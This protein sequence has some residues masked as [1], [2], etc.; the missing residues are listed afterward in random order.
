MLIEIHMIQNHS[1]SNL[2][3]DDLGAPKTCLFGGVPRARVSSQ[4]L[5]RSIRN[6]GN[7]DDVHNRGAG[8]FFEAMSDFIAVRTKFFPDLV[9]KA[10]ASSN[11]PEAERQKIV[12]SCAKIAKKEEGKAQRPSEE[13]EMA[14]DD[15]PRLPQLV[16]LE[17]SEA[18]EFVGKLA[19]MRQAK[20]WKD[21]YSKWIEGKLEKKA[22]ANFLYELSCAYK[23]RSVDIALFGRMTTSHAFEDVEAAMQAAHAISTHAVVNEV[24]YFTAV[25]DLGKTGGGAGHVDEA[26]FNS[27]CFYKYF[28]LDWDQLVSNLTPRDPDATAKQNAERLAAATLGHFIRAAA[29]T[30]PTGK[31][32]SF[33][34]NCEPSGILVEIKKNGKVP[35]S[36]ANAFAEPA[37]KIGDPPD[38]A[39]DCVSL[40]GRSIAQLGDHI[41]QLRKAY[42]TDS[43][44]LW[45]ALPLWRFPLQG[46]EREDDGRKA[47]VRNEKGEPTDKDKPPVRFASKSFDLLGGEAD[48]PPGLVEAMIEALG[49]NLKWADVKDAGKTSDMES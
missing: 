29:W 21:S 13:E 3:R 20:E 1:P 33:A 35:T 27:A 25:D 6:P 8:L 38:D 22:L 16:L 12:E 19:K 24:D 32:N 7:P 4:C 31:Q 23:R 18:Q 11:I 15:R 34:S 42:R 10:L 28:C 46:W 9:G 26:M 17:R 44:F 36:Y 2:N 30:T 45:Y 47:K 40:L 5:K 41:Y 43:T 48:K 14:R 39:P 49:I 37:R